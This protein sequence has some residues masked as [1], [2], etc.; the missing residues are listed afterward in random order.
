MSLPALSVIVPN[1]NHA[2]CLPTCLNAILRQ[3]APP[4]EVIVIDDA[5]PDNSMEVLD[6]FAR[7][8]P[9]IRVY[10]N[11]R[12]QGVSYGLNRGMD[13]ARGDYLFFPGADDEVKPGL[14]EKSLRLLAEHPQAALSCTIS[15]W[16]DAESGL[17]WHMGAGMADK[18]SYLSPDDVVRLAKRGKLM[19]VTAS[20]IMRKAPL[21]EAGRFIPELRWHSDWFANYITA[22]RYGF[23]FVPEP[24]SDF[25]LE[26]KSYYHRGRK[27]REHRE[28]LLK[29]VELLNSP[30]FADVRPRVRDGGALSLFEL[31][32]LRILLSR[33]DYRSFINWTFLRWTLWR[34]AEVAGNKVLPAWV[35][36]WIVNRLYRAPKNCRQE[37]S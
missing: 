27:S 2:H 18:P 12:N 4:A 26:P 11:E 20:S 7:R 35:A 5:S 33:P 25:L 3:S 8:Y 29:I 34:T 10:R 1:Y 16:Q 6:D 15:E 30:A 9:I 23:C 32:M 13:L 19:I 21:L 17:K 36:R 24:L 28:V 14:F 37:S 22:F 31:P